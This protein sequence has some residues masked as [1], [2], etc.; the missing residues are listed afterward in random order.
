MACNKK[1]KE[2]LVLKYNN[3][4]I[5]SDLSSRMDKSPSD[6]I[7][8][9]QILDYFVSSCVMPKT[10]INDRSS[11]FYSKVNSYN[12]PCKGLNKID[13]SDIKMGQE[14]QQYV[15]DKNTER[16]LSLDLKKL[17]D[18]INCSYNSR[19]EYGLDI[20][21]LLHQQIESGIN[22]KK[23]IF[24]KGENDSTEVQ[25]A[26]H[27]F[28]FTDGYLEFTKT[29]GNDK[30]YFGSKEI[31]AVREYCKLNNLTPIDAILKQPNFKLMPL[32]SINNQHV[33]LY[34]L[35]TNDRQIN[36]INGTIKNSGPLSDNNILKAVWKIWAKESGFKNFVWMGPT[37]SSIIPDDF[38]K[39]IIIK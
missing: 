9:N 24:L 37:T 15:N 21:S 31:I 10:K 23:T 8:I 16:S 12:S 11:L 18:Y 14:R 2:R 3:I 6:S 36:Q 26:N 38:I 20:L 33:N 4:L 13:I 28:L 19:D 25:F 17:R 5:Y 32:K 34:V 22:I 7:I 30:L 39:S 35:E 27:L 1:P 29:E